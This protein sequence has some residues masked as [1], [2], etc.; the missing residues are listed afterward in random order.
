MFRNR[1]RFAQRSL[2]ALAA[3]L[4]AGLVA[5]QGI[6][7]SP[8]SIIV[9]PTPTFNVQVWLDK[10]PTGLATPS[11]AVGEAVRISVRPSEDAYIYLYSIGADGEVVQILPNR[12]DAEGANNFVRAGNVRSFPP[13]DARYAFNVAPPQGLAKVMVVASRT[14]LNVSTLLSFRASSQFASGLLGEEGLASALSIIINPIPS[15]DWVSSTALYYV[16]NVP[17][18]AAFGMLSVTSEPVGGEVYVDR[19]FVGYTP[20]TTWLRPGSYDVE[21][22]AAGRSEA[23]RVNVRPDR[24]SELF[25]ALRPRVGAVELRANIGFARVFLNGSE[26]G[27]IPSGSGRLTLPDLEPGLHEVVLLAPGYRA[28]I[29]EV[30]VRAGDTNVVDVRLLR[31]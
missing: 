13:N 28:W 2:L 21:V 22:V 10:D 7:F 30:T 1:A 4:L 9:N 12:F 29:R 15:R 6:V 26:V 17:V 16:G 5:A 8:R 27:V 25:F 24:T 11:Y 14:P 19:N 31:R 23:Q 20:L 3:L 18:Q